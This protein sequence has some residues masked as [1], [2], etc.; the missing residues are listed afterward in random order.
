M[1]SADDSFTLY[2]RHAQ[3]LVNEVFIKTMI[4]FV[5]LYRDCL[6]QY[7]WQKIAEA[8]LRETKQPMDDANIQQRM[9]LR[10]DM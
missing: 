5:I 6:N 10:K 9:L 1:L 3:M 8:D 2:L 4:H 7:G